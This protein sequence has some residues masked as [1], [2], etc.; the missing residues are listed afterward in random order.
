MITLRMSPRMKD[1]KVKRE[2]IRKSGFLQEA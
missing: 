2:K 1:K